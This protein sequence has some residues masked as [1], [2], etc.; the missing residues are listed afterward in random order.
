[1]K[2]SKK[3]FSNRVRYY[4]QSRPS[5]PPELLDYFKEKLGLFTTSTIAD[6]GSGTGI[7]S[8]LF[9]KNGNVVFGIEPNQEMREAAESQL[10][11]HQNFVSINGSAEHTTLESNSIDV[12][13]VG[14]AFHWFNIDLSRNE[15]ARILKPQGWVALIWND[16]KINSTPF[17]NA[18]EN[19]LCHYSTDYDQVK[20]RNINPDKL[21]QFFGDDCWET[22]VFQN[23]QV[24]DQES[25]IGRV[26]SSSYIPM[27]GEPQHELMMDELRRLFEAYETNGVIRFE[28]DT[29]LYYGCLQ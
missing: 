20:E 29:K 6:V 28:Y 24:F 23:N 3:R 15:F 25:L 26:L 19:F 13:V 11:M 16:R 2:D 12:I 8:E 18:Y 27:E 10:T 17:L 14:Q 7:L 1:M 22:A 21:N 5:Y 9:L 4:I